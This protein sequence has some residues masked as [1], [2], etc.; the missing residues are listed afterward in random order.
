MAF[1]TCGTRCPKK[2]YRAHGLGIRDDPYTVA[3]SRFTSSVIQS[4]RFTLDNENTQIGR[5]DRTPQVIVA[6]YRIMQFA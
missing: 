3:A 2:Q 6:G 1:V 5:T 4:P